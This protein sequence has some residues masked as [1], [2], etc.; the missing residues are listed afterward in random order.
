MAD[1]AVAL[2]YGELD[3]MWLKESVHHAADPAATLAGLVRLLAPGGRLLVAMLPTSIE[4]PLFA[5]ALVRYEALQPDPAAIAQHLTEAGLRTELTYVEHEL[6]LERERY[7]SMI[8]ARNMSV[9]STFSDEELDAGIEEIR[10]RHPEPELVFPGRFAF[11]LGIR[12]DSPG[13]GTR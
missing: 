6:H 1:Q 2:P 4:Y 9:L 10:A 13:G 3:A 7:L 11:V 5:A 8:R 12:D